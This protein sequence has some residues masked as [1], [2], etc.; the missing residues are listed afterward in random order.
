MSVRDKILLQLYFPQFK[1]PPVSRFE[2][3]FVF[4]NKNAPTT[5]KKNIPSNIIFPEK[6]QQGEDKRTSIII[7]NIPKNVKKSKIRR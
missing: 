5:K 2:S 6:V 1:S 3:L 7:K 4:L